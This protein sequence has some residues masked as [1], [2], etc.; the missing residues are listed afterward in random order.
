MRLNIRDFA[1]I[2][3]AEIIVDGITVIA[4]ENNT[5]KSTVGK[6]IFSIFHALSGIEDKI[7]D[8][9]LKEIESTNRLIL[10]NFFSSLDISRSLIGSNVMRISRRIN[11]HLK[12]SLDLKKD[13]SIL[14]IEDII[15]KCIKRLGNAAVPADLEEW[16]DTIRELIQNTNEILCLP[17]ESIILEVITRSFNQVFHNQINSLSDNKSMEA[18]LDL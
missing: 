16:R 9:R 3:E 10:Q 1:K 17:E 13:I 15:V 8:E 12:R 2:K 4:G 7:V 5:G 6:I 18:S 14:E 11:L